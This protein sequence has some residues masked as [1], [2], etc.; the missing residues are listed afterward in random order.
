MAETEDSPEADCRVSWTEIASIFGII[1]LLLSAL[2]YLLVSIAWDTFL[3]EMKLS[4]YQF[5][6]RVSDPYIWTAL[7]G[8]QALASV[9][10]SVVITV[11]IIILFYLLV[12]FV[13]KKY[14]KNY[15]KIITIGTHSI[16]I[17]FIILLMIFIVI[18]SVT[19]MANK[20]LENISNSTTKLSKVAFVLENGQFYCPPG[21]RIICSER[22]C[23]FNDGTNST[24]VSLEKVMSI[25][26]ELPAECLAAPPGYEA[27]SAAALFLQ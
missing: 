23:G 26:T 17:I 24:V 13:V 1:L 18:T 14:Q 27:K 2:I 22:F 5:P 8:L 25:Q 4:P 19:N 21:V 9:R 3:F 12:I 16:F 10:T 20:E 7:V 11:V 15:Q 6:M